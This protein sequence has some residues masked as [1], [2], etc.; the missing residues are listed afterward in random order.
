MVMIPRTEWVPV[1]F[2]SLLDSG[3]VYIP[4]DMNY[5]ADRIRF[6]LEDV[7]PR[8]VI[9]TAESSEL[10][11]VTEKYPVLLLTALEE[12]TSSYAGGGFEGPDLEAADT[13][14]IIYTSGSTGLPKGVLVSHGNLGHFL[15]HVYRQYVQEAG[16]VMPFIASSSFDISVFQL[17]FPLLRGGISL[18]VDKSELQDLEKFTSLLRSATVLDTVPGVY[19]LLADYIL[20]HGLSGSFGHIERLFIGGD[21]IPDSLLLKLSSV[22]SSACITVTYGPTEGTIFCTD[23]VY[24]AGT[25]G[26][27]SRGSMIGHPISGSRIYILGNDQELLPA[28][29]DGEIC[30]G[31][32]GVTQG[33]FQRPEQ[34]LSR[35]VEHKEY[36]LLYRTGDIGRWSPEWVLEF[37]GRNDGQVKIRGHR[38]ELGEIENKLAGERPVQTVGR[39]IQGRRP[40]E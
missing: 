34:T 37:R 16:M 33:Y 4:V 36:G 28:G 14:Y 24:T 31:G 30:I 21:S 26:P 11:A 19:A 27:L 39:F 12:F 25:P 22:F 5:P 35:F 40:W 1:V 9:C 38:I 17:L 20:E 18:I 3:L 10:L 8:L 23:L 6:L 13:A 32:A 7:S 29:V 15:G 2:L